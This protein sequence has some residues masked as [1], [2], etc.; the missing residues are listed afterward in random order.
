MNATSY[1]HARA[2][3]RPA[4]KCDSPARIMSDSQPFTGLDIVIATAQ[5]RP[6]SSGVPDLTPRATLM[7]DGLFDCSG[8]L[9]ACN[10]RL[11]CS[12][13]Y[14]PKRTAG[15][16]LE[17]IQFLMFHWPERLSRETR[18]L[19][20]TAAELTGIHQGMFTTTKRLLV[21][22]DQGKHFCVAVATLAALW[23]HNK[24]LSVELDHLALRALRQDFGGGKGATKMLSSEST[25]DKMGMHDW[26]PL[27]DEV[28]RICD[29]PADA[30]ACF[31]S[32][33]AF[34]RALQA[35]LH[36]VIQLEDFSIQEEEVRQNVLEE[37]Q[38]SPR[39]PALIPRIQA[40]D[41]Q[42]G[43][44]LDL[45]MTA[46]EAMANAPGTKEEV[47]GAEGDDSEDGDRALQVEPKAK[48]S[49]KI[50]SCENAIATW[51]TTELST[52]VLARR[53]QLARGDAQAL[54]N[55]CL[56]AT[57]FMRVAAE[58]WA[59]AHDAPNIKPVCEGA[60]FR[61][62]Q[63]SWDPQPGKY[64]D[65]PKRKGEKVWE[66]PY[67][68]TMERDRFF[69]KFKDLG[70]ASLIGTKL[71]ED[72]PEDQQKKYENWATDPNEAF[73][74][75]CTLLEAVNGEVRLLFPLPED[76]PAWTWHLGLQLGAVLGPF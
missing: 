55:G 9:E 67:L 75:T 41:A 60:I 32:N 69:R 40:E 44:G 8:W 16:T 21:V 62:G 38:A 61:E 25:L 39:S 63:A 42:K 64:L 58:V 53:G 31:M 47:R 6:P 45:L 30:D 1:H 54:P 24:G 35:R 28:N 48:L 71:I 7:P 56:Q 20:T 26:V 19:V 66:G 73:L 51:A 76:R 50:A 52:E 33:C 34:C 4:R 46:S 2:R 72:M 59:N 68:H 70:E 13:G 17:S 23:L 49:G 12:D 65:H 29:A 36:R 18:K 43:V 57:A 11:E 74:W 22:D 3:E 27:L 5:A 15:N 37:S 14:D 10:H